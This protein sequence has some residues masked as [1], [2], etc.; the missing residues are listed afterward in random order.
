MLAMPLLALILLAL[1]PLPCQSRAAEQASQA[2]HSFALMPIWGSPTAANLSNAMVS[3]LSC[4]G[5][6]RRPNQSLLSRRTRLSIALCEHAT[7]C[8]C[9]QDLAGWKL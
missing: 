6:P 2:G 7:W 1:P 8:G 9:Q 4:S 3:L 5:P